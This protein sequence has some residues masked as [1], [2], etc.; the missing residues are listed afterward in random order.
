M[1]TETKA[2]I[3]FLDLVPLVVDYRTTRTWKIR[4]I[5]SQDVPAI[6]SLNVL[7]PIPS[8]FLCSRDGC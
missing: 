1:A 7:A 4:P 3:Q 2:E 8:C 6:K 5:R